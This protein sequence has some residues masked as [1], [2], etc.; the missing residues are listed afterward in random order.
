MKVLIQDVAVITANRKNEVLSHADV[1]IT[2]DKISY[3]GPTKAWQAEFNEVIDGRGK[4]VTP[5]FVNAH[6]HAAMS[7]LRS[8]AD[9][10]PLMK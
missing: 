10:M 6:G 1:V 3:V 9:D 2:N 5:G 7:L 4:L 8:Y